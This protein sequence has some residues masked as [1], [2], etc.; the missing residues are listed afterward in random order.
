MSEL[1]D[2]VSHCWRCDVIMSSFHREDVE[3]IC[4]IHLSHRQVSD[5]MV[6]LHNRKGVYSVRSGYYIARRVMRKE[7]W[8]ESS[9]GSSGLQIWKKLWK[10]RVPNKIK[11][12]GWRACHEILPTFCQ[13]C[14]KKN[15][16][17]SGVSLQQISSRIY[18]SRYMGVCYCS[19][20]VGRK[21]NQSVKVFN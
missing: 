12:F 13:P 2:S 21:F 1:I 17:R 5:S 10:L 6:W 11:V 9:R 8:T 16:I 20:C 7:D 18:C 19:R 15:H 4:K 14:L 3:A